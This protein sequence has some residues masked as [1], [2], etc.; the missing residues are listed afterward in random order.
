MLAK[1]LDAIIAANSGVAATAGAGAE[2][3]RGV[4]GTSMREALAWAG[5][6]PGE[7]VVDSVD[8]C[9]FAAITRR[10]RLAEVLTGLTAVYAPV[11]DR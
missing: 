10:D 6:G 3:Q 2:H 5:P 4:A 8:T 7:R 11:C 1:H 9:R